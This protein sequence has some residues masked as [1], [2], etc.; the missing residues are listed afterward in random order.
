MDNRSSP[1][2]Y[3]TQPDPGAFSDSSARHTRGPI[4]IHRQVGECTISGFHHLT[5]AG[6]DRPAIAYVISRQDAAL[7]AAAPD[8]L[9]LLQR[10]SEA[11]SPSPDVRTSWWEKRD[12]ALAK[13]V[14]S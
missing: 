4:S 13:A 12:A 7:Y 14:R 9:E 6:K 2:R 5:E 3:T 8:L 10:A 1:S 11:D